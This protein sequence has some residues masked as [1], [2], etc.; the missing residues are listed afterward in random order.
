MFLCNNYEE[1]V[2]AFNRINGKR[3]GL[4][5]INDCALVQV[6]NIDSCFCFV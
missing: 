5:L 3:N 2:V 4:G 1:A 6:Y